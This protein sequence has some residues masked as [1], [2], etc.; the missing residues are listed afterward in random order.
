MMVYGLKDS[1]ERVFLED[2]VVELFRR[3]RQLKRRDREA[4][5]QLFA[6]LV[7]P[8]VIVREATG[9]AKKDKRSRLSFLPDRPGEQLE[10]NVMYEKGL[11]YVGDWH[12]HPA[13]RGK[14]SDRDFTSIGELVRHSRHGFGGFLMIVVGTNEPP[15]GLA[16]YLHDG[17]QPHKLSPLPFDERQGAPDAT[18]EHD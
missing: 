11:H 12:T 16:V 10:I 14:P 15:E 8:S 6:R 17:K 5:G 1:T 18:E 3:S 2:D 9:P 4:G 13:P 7:P